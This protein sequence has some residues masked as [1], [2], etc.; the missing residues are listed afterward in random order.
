VSTTPDDRRNWH[1]STRSGGGGCVEVAV[2]SPTV[3]VRDSKDRSGP[4]LAFPVEG[5]RGF[6]TAV[7]GGAIG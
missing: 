3:A 6:I 5:W 2:G 1:I 4:E 7:R